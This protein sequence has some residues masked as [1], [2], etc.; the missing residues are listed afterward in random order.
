MPTQHDYAPIWWRALGFATLLALPA[1]LSAQNP[2]P[3][4]V[5][6]F[7][8]EPE[9]RSVQVS[10]DGNQ[11]AFLTT[12]ATGRV[13]IALMHLATGKVEPLVGAKDENI[14]FYFWKNSDWIVY[15]GDLGGNESLSLRSISLSKRKV[16]ALAES[17][18]ERY[19]DMANQA[20]I[21]DRLRFDPNR[22]LIEGNKSIGSYNF[23]VWLLDVRNGDRSAVASFDPKPDTQD[24]AVDHNGVIRGR[25]YLLGEKVIFEVRPEPDA[26][27]V[28]VAEFP[29]NKPQWGFMGFAA[30]NET[31][32]LA[33]TDRTD[34]AALHAFNVRTRTLS[35]VIFHNPE[36]EIE[37]LV[38][39]WDYSK[40]YGVR[41]V[42]DKG[43]YHFTDPARAALQQKIDASLPGTDNRI[44]S[45][46]QDE[47]V[48]VVHASSD[49]DP[50]TY[51]LL[52]LRHPAL[53]MIG[54][55]NRRINPANMR[56]MEPIVFAARD[57]LKIHGYL[58]R[59]AGAESRP[60]PLIV[61]P[62]GGPFGVRDEWGFNEEVQLLASRGYAV[63]QVNYRGSGGYGYSFQ[64][65]GQREWGGKMQDDLTDGVKWTIAQGIADPNRVAIMGGSYGG[66]AALAGV[67]FTPD[68]YCCAVNYVGVSDLNLITSWA[69]NRFSRGNDMFYREWVGDDKDYKYNRSPL[70]FVDR[71]RVPTL[72]AY[73][74]NDPRVKIE[75]WTR[76]EDKLK[77]YHK[78]YEI[79]IQ[80]NEGHGFRNEAGRIDYYTRVE[81]F[82]AKHL[83]GVHLAPLKILELPAKTKPN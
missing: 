20:R 51:Y 54:K 45:V 52:N 24:Q 17:Y 27:F 63:L 64:K 75:N 6:S 8:A 36:G 15:G 48:L 38:W 57:G 56:P 50:G 71:I 10:P 7:F 30:D 60:V 19:S 74:F 26:G 62:H 25:S 81:A 66:Y 78:P 49:R 34:T 55:V 53:M 23:G 69:E 72:H 40:L 79:I 76:L 29:A 32:Y 22:I 16:I 68:L 3:I 44:I 14:E 82:L 46:S 2:A 65:A 35:P 83:G 18:R 77:Q 33:T 80:D 28:K 5:E 70:N 42:T 41:Y 9:I 37:G 11:L 31:L 13:G 67:T 43:R 1:L 61:N 4:P 47:K 12:L 39:S 21:L 58:T 73:G 59:P